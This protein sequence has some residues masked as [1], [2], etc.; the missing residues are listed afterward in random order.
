MSEVTK[1]FGEVTGKGFKKF[2]KASGEHMKQAMLKPR[3]T[4]LKKNRR[5]K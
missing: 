4:K 5:G 1:I 3:K 2:H